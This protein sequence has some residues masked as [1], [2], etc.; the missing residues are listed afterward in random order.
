[1]GDSREDGARLFLVVISER[2]GGTGHKLIYRKFFLNIRK[3][4]FTERVIKNKL[5]RDVVDSPSLKIFKTHLDKS[6]S[7]LL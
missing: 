3:I 2:T 7:N 5:P 6:L 1:M 4:F